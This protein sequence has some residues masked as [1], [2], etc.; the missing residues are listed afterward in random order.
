MHTF[1][2]VQTDY[3][4]SAIVLKKAQQASAYYYKK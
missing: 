1:L 2:C 4:I 3:K